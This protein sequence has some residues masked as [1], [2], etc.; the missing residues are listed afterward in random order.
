[1]QRTT[2]SV[3]VTEDG[4]AL[5]PHADQVLDSVSAARASVGGEVSTP[6]G[7]L[8]VTA[9]ASFGRMHMV[10]ALPGFFERY[11]DLNVVVPHLG[12]ALP[13]LSTRLDVAVDVRGFPRTMGNNF[14]AMAFDYIC[15]I[16]IVLDQR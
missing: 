4:T 2:R 6:S 5:L 7:T 3:S 12:G 16:R 14:P 9:P 10:P 13:F 15:E 1:M 8:R 11:P